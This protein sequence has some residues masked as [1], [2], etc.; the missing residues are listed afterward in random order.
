[1]TP[2]HIGMKVVYIYDGPIGRY[3]Y[4]EL[5]P[6]IGNI[7]TIRGF[8]P[9][10]KSIVLEEIVNKKHLYNCHTVFGEVYFYLTSF[11]P[12]ITTSI[13]IFERMLQPAPKEKA[14]T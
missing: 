11:R 13:E 14:L 2:F 4:N 10:G 9:S 5:H 1:M 3:N 6:E 8:H 12:L 7:Y